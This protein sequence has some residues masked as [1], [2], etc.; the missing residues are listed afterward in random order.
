MKLRKNIASS[1]EGFVFNQ[2]TGDSFTTNPSGSEILGMLKE[3]KD[4]AEIISLVCTKYDVGKA[5]F[6]KDLD[7][8]ISQLKEFSILA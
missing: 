8:F 2:A 4:P 5:Q 1:E 3:E 7:D 6:E